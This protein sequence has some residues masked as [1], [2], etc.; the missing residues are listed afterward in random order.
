MSTT[1]LTLQGLRSPRAGARLRV[2]AARRERVALAATAAAVAL[3]PLAV[4]QGPGNAA[5]IDVLVVTAVLAALL[6][7]ATSGMPWRFPFAVPVALALV[8]GAVGA[9]FGPAPGLGTVALVQDILLVAWCWTLANVAHCTRN[10]RIILVAWTYSAIGWALLAFVGLATGTQVLT[11]Q[12]EKQGTRLQLTLADPSYTANYFFIS[13]MLMWATRRPRRRL[14]RYGAYAALVS[15]IVATGSNSGMVAVVVGFTVAAGLG[16]HRRYGLLPAVASLAC[17]VVVV[18]VAAS[19]VSFSSIQA[20]A[21]D[22]R[23]S[24][25]RQ[26]IGRSSDSAGQRENLVHESVRLYT[27]GNPLGEGPVSTKPRLRA[28]MAPLVKEAHDDYLAALIERGPLG[29]IGILVLVATLLVRGVHV[30]TKLPA[31]PGAVLVRPNALVGAVA[32]T[33]VGG[34]VYELLHVRHVWALFAL[35]AAASMWRH[36]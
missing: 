4:P 29:F 2:E 36:R 17:A 7:A 20:S 22:S 13:M 21:H 14:V 11:G 15:A 1:A 30:A 27:I 16:I 25:V 28:E 24:F 8:G 10:L 32:G 18:G 26:G 9:L 35:V 23:W 3:L 31:G 5:P 6:W 12:V 33:L 34:T 19:N